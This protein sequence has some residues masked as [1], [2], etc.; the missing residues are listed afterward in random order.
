VELEGSSLRLIQMEQ[1]AA[2]L[3]G[4]DLH[5]AELPER[6]LVPTPTDAYGAVKYRP[7]RIQL[8]GHRRDGDN[9]QREDERDGGEDEIQQSLPAVPV[10]GHRP[11]VP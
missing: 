6:E 4:A 5:G 1:E 3:L 2:E 7:R 10:E 9:G 11:N 8:D